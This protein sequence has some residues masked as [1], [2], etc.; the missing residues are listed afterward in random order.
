[1]IDKETKIVVVGHGSWATAL[2]KIL[3]DNGRVV[4]WYVRND[5]V[6]A[7][8][9]KHGNNPKYLSQV[10]FAS[11][12]IKL[13]GDVNSAINEAQVVILAIPSAFVQTVMSE[14]SVSFADKFVVSAIKGIV[15]DVWLTIGEWLHQ[16]F[17][18]PFS[19][20]GVIT[21][22]CHA[23]EVALVRLSYLTMVCKDLDMAHSLGLAFAN[24]YIRVTEST[25]IY[26]VE[27]ASVLKNIYAIAGGVCHSLGYGDNFMAVLISNAAIEIEHFL[28][29]TYPCDRQIMASAYLGDLLVTCYSQF[30]RNRTFGQMIG[31]G[32]AVRSAQMEM[33]M[34]AEGYYST[35]CLQEV[36][37]RECHKVDMPIAETMYGILYQK[38]P[39]KKAMEKLLS[40][41]I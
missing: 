34:V 29:V 19:R 15:P 11:D 4:G 27:W 5:D 39:A 16:N 13:Y 23:E 33:G 24:D 36:K 14:L 37:K 35:A 17:G 3:T 21:G 26:G 7:H 8:I 9:A 6:R 12:S 41:L 28:L 18:L 31:K 1:M 30:S 2:V 22:P 32:Y 25:D 10:H 40:K 20:I 38:H